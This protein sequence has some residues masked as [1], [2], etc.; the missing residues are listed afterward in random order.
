MSPGKADY[1]A[2]LG[3]FRDASQEEIKRA[4]FEAAQRLH[5]DKNIAPGETE[6]FLEIQQAYEVLSNPKRRSLYDATLPPEI[7]TNPLV[8]YELTFSR[9]NLV[10]LREPQLLYM[11]REAGPREEKETLPSPPLNICLVLDRSTSMQG[12][13]M[14]MVKA[15]AIQLLRSLRPEDVFSVVAFSDFAEVVIPA[16]LNA[17]KKKQE[18]RIQM[19]YPSGATEIYNGLKAGYQEVRRTAD[20]SR[21]NHIILLTDGH[22]YGDEQDCLR[23]AEE[24][25]AQNIGISGMGIGSDWNDIFLDALAAKTGGS[26]AY[27]STPK[28]IQRLLVE[29]FNALVSV[30][31]DEVLLEFERREDVHINYAFRL[32]PDGSSLITDSPMRLGPILR[33]T[34]LHVLFELVVNPSALQADK[35]SLLQGSLKVSITARPTPVPP[36]RLNIVR[37]V[38][39]DPSPEPP[40]TRILSA[41]SRLTLYRM[42]ER[43]RNAADAG[44]FDV[45]ARQLQALATHLLSKGEHD[46]AKT[47]LFEAEHLE[48][49]HAWSASGNKDVKYKTRALLLGGVKENAK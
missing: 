47:A 13:K 15:T 1:Y 29:K 46:M 32:Q 45:A 38:C 18:G 12:D 9:P 6:L 42:Q 22:T 4:Y 37:D 16:A 19:I 48:K 11:L 17:D 20:P 8:K 21:V 26:S 36:I 41:L 10:K 2:V 30:Y 7:E 33:D 43:A 35:L 39:A 49:M 25:A 44:Q 28:D 40:P 24:A 27:I 14:D 3:V 5:P 34:P 23:L 31:A